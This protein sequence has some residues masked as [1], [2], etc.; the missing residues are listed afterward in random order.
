MTRLESIFISKELKKVIV[1]H[2][3]INEIKDLGS[4][5]LDLIEDS[6]KFK[7]TKEK[8]ELIKP[9]EVKNE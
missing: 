2:K 9:K 4:A 7:V 1:F 3:T 8:M 6:E 5:L